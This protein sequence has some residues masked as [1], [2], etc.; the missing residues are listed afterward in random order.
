MFF[1]HAS[2]EH[3][4]Y[5][6]VGTTSTDEILY[7]YLNL[8]QVLMCFQLS[9]NNNLGLVSAFL[10]FAFFYGAMKFKLVELELLETKH[11]FIQSK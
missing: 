5:S 3:Q 8:V 11:I 4:L 6:P 1:V 9:I 10:F 7:A 2:D